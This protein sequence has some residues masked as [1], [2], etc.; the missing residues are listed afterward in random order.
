MER[1][2]QDTDKSSTPGFHREGLIIQEDNRPKELTTATERLRQHAVAA[3]NRLGGAWVAHVNAFM[4]VQ[5]V[6]RIHYYNELYSK[7]LDVP[8]VICEFGIQHGAGLVQIM[9][10]RNFYE[11]HNVGRYIFGFDTFTGFVGTNHKDGDLVAEGDYSVGDDYYD[12][13]FDLLTLHES[14][15]P[16]SYIRRFSLV[17]GDAAQTIDQW[18]IDNPHAIV[19]MA[20]FD[21]DIYHPTKVVLEKI[22][23]RLTKG[24]LLVFD[25]LNHGGFPGETRALDEV[26][27]LSGVRLRKTRWQPYSAY[28]VW[29]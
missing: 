14:Y 18:L 17:K 4:P 28:C 25:E 15:Q 26:I 29:E 8:G 24:S 6:A 20:I 5:A 13:L 21:M 27:K 1:P 12:T 9:N 7:I 2:N 23:P 10:C 22:I 16:R 19:A 3:L 11:P